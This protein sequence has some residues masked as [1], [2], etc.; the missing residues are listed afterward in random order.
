MYDRRPFPAALVCLI[1]AAALAMVGIHFYMDHFVQ[2]GDIR[3]EKDAQVLDISGQTLPDLTALSELSDPRQLDLRGTGLT[4]AQYTTLKAWYPRCTILW[5]IP[6]QGQTYPQD[7]RRLELT[8]LT[9]EDLEALDYFT[10]LETITARD[11]TDY[12]LLTSLRARRPELNY[13]YDINVCGVNIHCNAETATVPGSDPAALAKLLPHLIRLKSVTLVP[14]LE[15]PEAL[16]ALREA[17]P[18]LEVHWFVNAGGVYAD[19]TTTTL[20]LTGIPMTVAQAEALLPYLPELTYLD[21]SDCGISNEEM[22]A[23][24][25]RHENVQI[26]WTVSLGSWY[27][28]KTD[29]TWFMPVK[30]GFYPRGNDLYNLRYCHDI[31]ALD[32]GH[33]NVSSCE[34]VAYMPKLQYL[35]LAD[36]PIHD[37]TPLTGLT[38]LVYL[39]LFLTDVTDY[40]PLL[41]LT[42][43]ED[44]NLHYT[45]GD[46][47]IILQ[48]TWLKNLWWAGVSFYTQQQLYDAIPGC[49]FEFHSLSSTGAGWRELPNYYAQ[50]DIFGMWYMTG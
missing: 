15:A 40:T 19:E 35:L 39:E 11:F 6:F 38:E 1:L 3:F 42:S 10:E 36:T 23:L 47:D 4:A 31:I 33:M 30:N 22:D 25:S 21:L 5:D 13:H 17:F 16:F 45:W 27:R 29:I 8:S 14:P 2:L 26:V 18:E 50:R 9:E 12:T 34:F 41:S 46:P 24:N 20:D 32:I 49:H 43:L 37:I 28:T 44:L 7:T 48:M